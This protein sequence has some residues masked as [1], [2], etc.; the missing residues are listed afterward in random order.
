MSTSIGKTLREAAQ[1]LAALPQA[2]PRLEAELLLGEVTGLD[3]AKL[4]A[5]PESEI[6][7]ADLS[8]FRALVERRIAGEPIA[9]VRGR[10]AFWTLELRVTRDTLIPRPETELLVELALERLPPDAPLLVLD[11]GSGS[12]AIA[13]ALASERPAWTLIATD[14]SLDAAR[15]AR[16]NLSRLAAKNAR[17]INCHWLAPIADRSLH[18]LICNPPYIPDADPHLKRGDLLFE[19]RWA[20]AAGRDGL[21]AIRELGAQAATRL[22]PVGL[23]VLEHGFDQ[24]QAVRAILA[25]QGFEDLSTHRDL[26]GHERATSA[27]LSR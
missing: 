2:S 3:R 17:V 25:R 20:L 23:I 9:Y 10:Q 18:A 22:R 16:D 4:L 7:D 5:W 19:P 21:D 12:G 24:A 26:A 14:R 1:Q 13:A 15:V 8:R 11:A 27:R 6:R